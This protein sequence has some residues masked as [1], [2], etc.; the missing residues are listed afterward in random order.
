MARKKTPPVARLRK[1]HL[2]IPSTLLSKL[3]VFQTVV[4]NSYNVD[5]YGIIL[6]EGYSAGLSIEEFCIKHP[7]HNNPAKNSTGMSAVAITRTE[8]GAVA[9]VDE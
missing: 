5:D 2:S 4:S 3:F 7:Q 9:K 6:A 1:Q 8:K